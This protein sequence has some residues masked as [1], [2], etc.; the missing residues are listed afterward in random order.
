V[1]AKMF[2]KRRL[3]LLPPSR[4]KG[5]KNWLKGLWKP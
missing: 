1:G 2:L 3:H 5:F 4:P